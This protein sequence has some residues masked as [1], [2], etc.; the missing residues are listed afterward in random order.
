MGGLGHGDGDPSDSVTKLILRATTD[1]LC[2]CSPDSRRET[3]SQT[4]H[5]GHL[6]SQEKASNQMNATELQYPIRII[7]SM[8]KMSLSFY[9]VSLIKP[10]GVIM[11]RSG[12]AATMP[13]LDQSVQGRLNP[14]TPTDYKG[15]LF[16]SAHDVRVWKFSSVAH[17]LI[18]VTHTKSIKPL[19]I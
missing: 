12:A 15:L 13:L 6:H 19:W 18:Y 16:F 1:L 4:I 8:K 2:R 10:E 17:T 11:R 7:Y 9:G 14:T 5:L 3:E